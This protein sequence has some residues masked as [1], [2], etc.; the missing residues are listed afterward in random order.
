MPATVGGSPG[1]LLG[2]LRPLGLDAASGPSAGLLFY[3]GLWLA[4]IAYAAAVA[5]AREIPRRSATGALVALALLFALAPPLLSQDVFSY[6]AY[7]RLGAVHGLDPYAAAPIAV[8]G[9]AVFGFAGSKG[10]S[11]VYGPPFTLATYLLAGASVP[12]AFWALKAL[13]AVCALGVV[14]L[15]W[16][17]AERRGLDPRGPALLVGLNPAWLVHVVGAAHN[18]ALTTVALAAALFAYASGRQATSGALATAATAVK[19]S[20]ALPVAFLVAGARRH[21]RAAAAAIAAAAVAL[22]VIAAGLAG[23]GAEAFG[24][25]DA[26]GSNQART[27]SFSLPYK[28]AELF[29]V[30]LSGER[31]DYRVPVRIA[32]ASAFGG[33][34]AWLLWRAWRGAD[35]IAMAGWATL[36]LLLCSAWLV[37]WYVAWLLPLAALG[38]SRGLVLATVAVTAWTLAIAIP[39]G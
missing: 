8:P 18:E 3:A 24:W 25:L 27:S 21:A 14:A 33:I 36:A 13:A 29:G 7:A 39:F 20:A 16:R 26:V 11:S 28:T 4:L 19:A 38:A 30:L 22:A 5:R 10:A 34:A 15:V 37:P 35:A 31:L 23:F 32:Y 12:V 2:P 9:D 17:A 1:W 6:V